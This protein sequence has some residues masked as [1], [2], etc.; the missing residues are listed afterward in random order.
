MPTLA[1]VAD[2]GCDL[3]TDL[4]ERHRIGQVSLIARFG[5]HEL[6]DTPASRAEFWQRYDIS[7]PPQTSGPPAGAWAEAFEQAL[8]RANEVIA[9]TVT[10]KHSGTH[11]SA[12]IA[13]ADFGGR[14]HVFDSW[15]VS[16]GEGLQTLHASQLAEAGQPVETILASLTSMRQRMR[17]YFALDTIEA[18][19]RGGRLA[20]VI[21]A[22]KRMSSLIS[23]K[24]IL[25]IDEGVIRFDGAARSIRR[26]TQ[27]L[28]ERA[29]NAQVYA[30][31]GAPVG[32][33]IV[34]AGVGHTRQHDLALETA[35]A[36]AALTGLPRASILVAEAGP[37]L[38]AHAGPGALGL[39]FVLA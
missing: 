25:S 3:P 27:A 17:V 29:Q 19:Q 23:I 34:V 35:D 39:G 1:I 21:S 37:A 22:L 36:L 30:Q 32:G 20:P 33:R 6:L 31:V 14:V 10:S 13:A 8:T 18:V 16:L 28:L 24:P 9:V 26:A 15:S 2:S 5:T 7:Q 11:N 12:V 38:G 4:L